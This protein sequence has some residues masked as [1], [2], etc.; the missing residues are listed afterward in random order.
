MFDFLRRSRSSSP[1]VE[2]TEK[3]YELKGSDICFFCGRAV[4]ASARTA[5]LSLV[6]MEA[7]DVD[8]RGGVWQCH[9]DCAEHHK[10]P[11]APWGIG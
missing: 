2:V 10:H 9:V 3:H 8:I 6:E 5:T 7:G 11:D 1:K 4:E